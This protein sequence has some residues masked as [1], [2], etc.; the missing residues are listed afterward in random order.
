MQPPNLMLRLFWQTSLT[1]VLMAGLL[2]GGAGD[3]NWPQAWIYLAIFIL[4]SASFGIWLQRH[5]PGLLAARL[6]S[7]VQRGQPLWDRVFLLFFIAAWF[8]W[9]LLM[10]LDARRWHSSAIPVWLNVSAACW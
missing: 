8:G 9:M 5:D 2:F 4:C 10:G 1:V 7:P 6:S 3:L